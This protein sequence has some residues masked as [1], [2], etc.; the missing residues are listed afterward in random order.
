MLAT[1]AETVLAT[2]GVP[3]APVPVAPEGVVAEPGVPRGVEVPKAAPGSAKNITNAYDKNGAELV[4]SQFKVVVIQ[5]YQESI[6]K[7]NQASKAS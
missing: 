2:P 1:E 3:G 4:S 6:N 5:I 7:T